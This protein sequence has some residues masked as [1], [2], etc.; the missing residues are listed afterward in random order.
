MEITKNMQRRKLSMK[1]RGSLRDQPRSTRLLSL[2]LWRMMKLIMR[3]RTLSSLWPSL[4][5]NS[6]QWKISSRIYLVSP[7]SE[8]YN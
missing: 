1:K 7:L 2:S 4:A 8:S 5:T 6:S 3:K